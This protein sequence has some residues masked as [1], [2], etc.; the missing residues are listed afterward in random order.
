MSTSAATEMRRWVGKVVLFLA[1]TWVVVLIAGVSGALRGADLPLLNIA[2][3]LV[4]GCAF[5]PAAY[6]SV[7]LHRVDDRGTLDRLW[8]KAVI[9]GV[10]G[11][12]LLF[13]GAYGLYRMG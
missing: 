6:Y 2:I 3:A 1:F 10:A 5:V 8:P 12:I 13:G 11:M 9:Y 4:P 7:Q